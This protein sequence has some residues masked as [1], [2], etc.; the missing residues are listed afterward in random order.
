MILSNNS[1]RNIKQLCPVCNKRWT[2]DLNI[3]NKMTNAETGRLKSATRFEDCYRRCLDDKIAISNGKKPRLI[4]Q[5][6]EDNLPNQLVPIKNKLQVLLVQCINIKHKN[7][8]QNQF[9]FF[10]SE[11]AFTWA[12]FGYICKENLLK[13][14]ENKLELSSAIKEILFW[15]S[16]F[17]SNTNEY[18]RQVF[19]NASNSC[20]ENK[21]FRT[22]PDIII[23]TSTEFIFIEIKVDSSNPIIKED[24]KYKLDKYNKKEYY[25]D[26]KKACSLYELIRN[27]TLGNT[28]AKLSNK[29]FKLINLLPQKYIKKESDSQYQKDFRNGLIDS[30][31]SYKIMSW[32]DLFEC[33]DDN[34]RLYLL[35]RMNNILDMK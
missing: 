27:W 12:F 33:V 24:E 29:S 2:I 22:E 13:E 19:V 21:D 32:E 20:N 31:S 5:N 15:G 6:I 11:D 14:L 7:S 28:M 3:K 23:C 16:P 10:R 1:I 26:F 8:K 30:K 34:Y 4:F 18:Y 25:K 17:Y 35:A 9:K